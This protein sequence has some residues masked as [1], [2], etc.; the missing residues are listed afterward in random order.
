MN[1]DLWVSHWWPRVYRMALALTGREADAEDLA[2][3]TLIAALQSRFR[4]ESA[5]STWLYGILIRKHRT[6]SRK[7]PP[8]PRAPARPADLSEA[9]AMLS[10]LPERMRVVAALFYVEGFSVDEISGALGVHRSTVKWRL[11]R[12]RQLLRGGY[13]HGRS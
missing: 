9:L 12:A 10:A 13:V 6:R 1:R 8:E 2:Q 5:E 4:G 7:R 3:E 11:F